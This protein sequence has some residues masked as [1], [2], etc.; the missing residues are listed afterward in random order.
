MTRKN[1]SLFIRA[2]AEALTAAA[3]L[4]LIPYHKAVYMCFRNLTAKKLK[5]DDSI[6]WE[7]GQSFLKIPYA[8][9][10]ASQYLDLYVPSETE[11][12]ELMV[13]VHGGGFIDGDS[14]TRQAQFMYR[15][16]RE[17]GYA[18]ASVNYRLAQEEPFPGAL[19]D[20]KAAVRFLRSHAE[21]YGYST[22]R[23]TIFGESAGGY[24]ASMAALTNDNEYMSVKYIGQE[25]DEKTGSAASAS[26]DV[27]ID[28]YGVVEL[29]GLNA[30]TP[31][32]KK[33][34]VPPLIFR[35]A[36]AWMSP[37]RLEGYSDCDSFW[38]RREISEMS[39]EELE[40]AGVGIYVEENLSSTSGPA[41]MIIHG[42]CDITVPLLQSERFYQRVLQAG[43]NDKVRFLTIPGQGHA[44]DMLY[45]ESVL[46]Q[47]DRFIKEH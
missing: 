38:M 10:S 35:I 47:V 45:D 25:E 12:P 34:G 4:L 15:Y 7:G 3:A 11:H 9:D 29:Q 26:V 44:T 14:Q 31:D 42:D 21:E 40:R 22:D 2:A 27:L 39:T 43:G 5:L 30:E 17:H 28:Y 37:G 41:V 18:C 1:T 8:E 24:L 23:I 20:V 13:I 32:W 46:E 19:E 36:N 16:F 33:L 6:E